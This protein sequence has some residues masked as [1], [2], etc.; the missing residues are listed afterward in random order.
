MTQYC[1]DK[2]CVLMT[3]HEQE[4]WMRVAIVDVSYKYRSIYGQSP[5]GCERLVPMDATKLMVSRY[6]KLV[7]GYCGSQQECQTLNKALAVRSDCKRLTSI[8]QMK[9]LLWLPF[10][11]CKSMQLQR[12]QLCQLVGGK[13]G[14]Q[15]RLTNQG[16]MHSVSC[17]VRVI[18]G[19]LRAMLLCIIVKRVHCLIPSLG[20][21]GCAYTLTALTTNMS[22]SMQLYATDCSEPLSQSAKVH[23]CHYS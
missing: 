2:Q 18:Q 15:W 21:N 17:S 11:C 1:S 3:F 7:I 22:Q 9:A 19:Q 23:V 10:P 16:E 8:Y 6:S 5:N 20:L 13:E 4:Q 14:I 12:T